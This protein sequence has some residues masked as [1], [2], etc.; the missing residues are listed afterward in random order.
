MPTS[1]IEGATTTRHEH[2][3]EFVEATTTD[4][5]FRCSKC[6]QLLIEPEDAGTGA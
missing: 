3:F 4:T 1:V 6:S 5:V 2:R